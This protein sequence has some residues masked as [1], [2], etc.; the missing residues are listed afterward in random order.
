MIRSL[1]RSLVITVVCGAAALTLVARAVGGPGPSEW[2]DDLSPIAKAEWDYDKAAHL[3]ERAGFGATPEEIERLATLT[4]ERAVAQL[5][6]Y[7]AID[8]NALKPFDESGIWDKGMD[9]FPPSRAE[10]VRLA[11]DRG[12][13]LGEKM[14][15]PGSPR[16]LQPIVDNSSTAS[17]PIRS[18]RSAS[19]CGGHIGCWRHAGRSKRS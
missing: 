18:R 13:G 1:A 14:L 15:P 5:V 3:I 6:N 17:T 8:N 2:V 19:G 9:P 11:R 7:E 16:R 4:P 12:E 10:A